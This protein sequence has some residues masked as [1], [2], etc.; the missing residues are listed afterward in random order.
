MESIITSKLTTKSQATGRCT[1]RFLQDPLLLPVKK[2]S[3]SFFNFPFFQLLPT[4]LFDGVDKLFR[5]FY[6]HYII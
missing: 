6:S 4:T 2:L 1:T 5:H 3:F